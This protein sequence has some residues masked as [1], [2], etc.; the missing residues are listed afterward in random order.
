MA[1]PL[2]GV[3]PADRRELRSGEA[4]LFVGYSELDAFTVGNGAQFLAKDLHTP[5]AARIP[6]FFLICE[7]NTFCVKP[8]SLRSSEITSPKVFVPYPQL[9]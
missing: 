6:S 1:S 9:A 4:E 5:E 8:R 2:V 3:E 7:A